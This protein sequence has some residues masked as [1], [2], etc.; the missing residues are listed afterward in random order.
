[1]KP[2]KICNTILSRR[3][4]RRTDMTDGQENA[5][6]ETYYNKESHWLYV[7]ATK[8]FGYFSENLKMG[9]VNYC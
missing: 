8:L 1:M 3:S 2:P 4:L 6:N 9:N 7:S 5:G